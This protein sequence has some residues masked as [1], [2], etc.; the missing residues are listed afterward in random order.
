M[1]N[2]PKRRQIT[3]VRESNESNDS[4]SICPLLKLPLELQH[5]VFSLTHEVY[6]KWPLLCIQT[7]V[8][9][10][11]D[12]NLDKHGDF[13]SFFNNSPYLYKRAH[14]ENGKRHGV[15]K[16]WFDDG[17]QALEVHYKE[18]ILHGKYKRWHI[19]GKL[20][21]EVTYKN[22]AQVQLTKPRKPAFS[23]KIQTF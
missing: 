22:G 18:G 10:R 12:N 19:S 2:E 20:M 3:D 4:D 17:N 9:S 23:I 14:F 15:L 1:A 7:A 11:Y 6:L 16:R 13:K 21:F 5:A 8:T